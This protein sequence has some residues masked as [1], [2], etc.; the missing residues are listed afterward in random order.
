MAAV[1]A[2]AGNIEKG[3]YYTEKDYT[4]LEGPSM[5][6]LYAVLRHREHDACGRVDGGIEGGLR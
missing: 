3:G 4:G 5:A 1:L 2:C 6:Q